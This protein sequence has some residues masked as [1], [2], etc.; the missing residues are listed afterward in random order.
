MAP[1]LTGCA[2]IEDIHGNSSSRQEGAMLKDRARQ[3]PIVKLW[4]RGDE[5]RVL[6]K[7]P[8]NSMQLGCLFVGALGF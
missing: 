1:A 6:S 2:R 3:D 5:R 8:I 4:R 7:I